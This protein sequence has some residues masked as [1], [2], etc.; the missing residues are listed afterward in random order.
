MS[1]FNKSYRITR[2]ENLATKCWSTNMWS[3]IEISCICLHLS[4][5]FCFGPCRQTQNLTGNYFQGKILEILQV[6]LR[7]TRC[8]NLEIICQSCIIT[9]NKSWHALPICSVWL[10]STASQKCGSTLTQWKFL[11]DIKYLTNQC[12]CPIRRTFVDRL[13]AK[14]K[15]Q[16]FRPTLNVLFHVGLTKGWL[17]VLN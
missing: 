8:S 3:L 11:M 2:V 4:F 1:D 12:P 15:T 6:S 16:K 10:Q 13:P 14:D 17:E 9:R 5:T 7:V